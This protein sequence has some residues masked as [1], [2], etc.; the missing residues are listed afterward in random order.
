MKRGNAW[1]RLLVVA[2]VVVVVIFGA[3]R[4]RVDMHNT[5]CHASALH[6]LSDRQIPMHGQLCGVGPCW[7]LVSADSKPN[8]PFP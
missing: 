2:V 4:V 6:S 3:G 1:L 5:P 7:H 8:Y